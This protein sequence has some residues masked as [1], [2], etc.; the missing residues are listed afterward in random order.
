MPA[1]GV[2]TY[3]VICIR[4]CRNCDLNLPEGMTA[5]INEL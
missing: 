2:N 3:E 4:M 1:D 5:S